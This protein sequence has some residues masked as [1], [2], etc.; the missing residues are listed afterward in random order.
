[1]N[2]KNVLGAT[3]AVVCTILLLLPETRAQSGNETRK[4]A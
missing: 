3:L 4:R 2:L 1:M